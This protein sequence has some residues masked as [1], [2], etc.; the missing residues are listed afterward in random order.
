MAEIKKTMVD[1]L[2]FVEKYG[3]MSKENLETFTNTFCVKSSRS[4]GESKP[5]EIVRLFDENGNTIA[6]RCSALHVWLPASEFNGDIEKMS[7]SRE[8][9]KLKTANLRA[10]EKLIREGDAIRVEAKELTDPAEKLEKFEEYDALLEQ[11]KTIKTAPISVEQCPE[12]FE[13]YNTVEEVAEALNVP[14][15]TEKPAEEVEEVEA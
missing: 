9:N 1:A 8:A 6:R 4:N 5:R 7:I 10:A 3:N 2:A 14:V 15:I 11:A 13:Y 12:G